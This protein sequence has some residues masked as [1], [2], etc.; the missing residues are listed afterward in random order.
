MRKIDFKS[1]AKKL[2]VE[3]KEVLPTFQKAVHSYSVLYAAIYEDG[4]FS[5]SCSSE[6]LR[7][8]NECFMLVSSTNNAGGCWYVLYYIDDIGIPHSEGFIDGQ[9]SIVVNDLGSGWN[10]R[11]GLF[12]RFQETEIARCE[13]KDSKSSENTFGEIIR[14]YLAVRHC[15]TLDEAILSLKVI[16]LNTVVHH[17]ADRIDYLNAYFSEEIKKYKGLLDELKVIIDKK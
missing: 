3:A 5:T 8:A 13:W 17:Q 15:E 14:R 10:R 11:Y 9:W 2:E 4:S 7:N 12:L 16:D 6:F 1:I